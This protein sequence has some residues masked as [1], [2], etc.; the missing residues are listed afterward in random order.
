MRPIQYVSLLFLFAPM[1]S[2]AALPSNA[3]SAI[4]FYRNRTSAFAS[5]Q[6]SRSQLE[7]K[8]IRTESD[9]SFL[10]RWDNK[11]F[12]IKSTSLLRDIQLS[13]FAD[14]KKA[15]TLYA[16]PRS[17]AR[18]V[19]A[20][21]EKSY[22]EIL[23]TNEHWALIKEHK[24]KTQGWVPLM[25]LKTRHDDL[26]IFRNLV[27]TSLRKEPS[28][29]SPTLLQIP[30][31]ERVIPLEITKSFVKISYAGRIGYADITHFVSRADF[32][33]LVYH[34]KKGWV[35]AQYRN[36]DTIIT[37]SGESLS[38]NEV[39]GYVTNHQ[40]GIVLKSDSV[41]SPPLKA[42]VEIIKLEASRWALSK[43][44]GHGEVWWKQKD[45]L[46][47]EQKKSKDTLST[48]ELLKR[49]IYSI[50]FES[51]NSLRGIVSSQGIYRT[52]D[53]LTWTKID[54][55]GE[56]NNPVSIHPNG[57]WFAGSYKSSNKGKSFEPFIRWDKLAQAIEA[58]SNHNPKTLKLT[59]IDP[60]P[61]SQVQISVDTGTRQV[62]LKS[63]I[64]DFRWDV[65]T[66]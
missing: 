52:E 48:D 54:L 37:A 26:G 66:R 61:N 56:Q 51:K 47:E 55:F 29:S 42:R 24:E 28:Y 43:V 14:L 4:S 53:G 20:L 60:L 12:S 17:S 62:K 10:A 45:I 8:L 23:D 27:T 65:I 46:S 38:L 16:D 64:G 15:T 13:R 2:E 58:A 1:F 59:R 35:P 30:F 9:I 5:G 41:Q 34:Q 32:A 11:D 6:A 19:K 50:A 49:Q 44:D 7:Q 3:G 40:R 21:P 31:L 25:L 18:I 63:I 57:T 39:I 33:S 22:V 36:N